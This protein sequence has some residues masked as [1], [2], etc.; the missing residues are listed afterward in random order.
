MLSFPSLN[1]PRSTATIT[2]VPIPPRGLVSRFA[3]LRSGGFPSYAG[4]M[5]NVIVSPGS[6]VTDFY[7]FA[8]DCS[9]AASIFSPT[10]ISELTRIESAAL[11]SAPLERVQ[12]GCICFA[13]HFTYTNSMPST[14]PPLPGTS[15]DFLLLASLLNQVFERV[16]KL[17]VRV[18]IILATGAILP[19]A[20]GAMGYP[21]RNLQIFTRIVLKHPSHLCRFVAICAGTDGPLELV[22]GCLLPALSTSV[23]W[24]HGIPVIPLYGVRCIAPGLVI[25]QEH[26]FGTHSV[27]G[28]GTPRPLRMML[29]HLRAGAA[30]YRQMRNQLQEV[31]HESVDHE[32]VSDII[33]QLTS[34]LRVLTNAKD[35]VGMQSGAAVSTLGSLLPPYDL[36]LM[37]ACDAILDGY[38]SVFRTW[39]TAFELMN[40]RRR[41]FV[42]SIRDFSGLVVCEQLDSLRYAVRHHSLNPALLRK[43]LLTLFASYPGP[44]ACVLDDVYED[45]SLATF[46]IV[47]AEAQSDGLA[48]IAS[49]YNAYTLA[50]FLPIPVRSLYL[51]RRL[52]GVAMCPWLVGVH[53]LPAVVKFISVGDFFRRPRT[54]FN[55]HGENINSFM[56][57]PCSA[58]DTY[59]MHAFATAAVT[60][61]PELYHPD[62]LAA[63]VAAVI[64]CIACEEQRNLVPGGFWWEEMDRS[65]TL[66][67]GSYPVATHASLGRYMSDVCSDDLFHTC[68]SAQCPL[69]ESH[70]QCPALSKF[71]LGVAL[72]GAALDF[73]QFRARYLALVLEYLGR[74][75][76]PQSPFKV[77]QKQGVLESLAAPLLA[78]YAELYMAS[79]YAHYR[80]Y[81]DTVNVFLTSLRRVVAGLSV[82]DVFEPMEVLL[83]GTYMSGIQ[84]WC[85]CMARLYVYTRADPS[86]V[87]VDDVIA[88]MTLPTHELATLVTIVTATGSSAQRHLVARRTA[89]GNHTFFHPVM[90]AAFG[91]WKVDFETHCVA[92]FE[93]IYA[94]DSA[95]LHELVA[96][97][98]PL[99]HEPVLL[100]TAGVNTGD[101]AE[102]VESVEQ[103]WEFVHF[104]TGMLNAFGEL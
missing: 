50:K 24:T 12:V 56:P 47:V 86:A 9:S 97:R 71:L 57:L 27:D 69:A 37:L 22:S 31:R 38:V 78:E 29:S 18:H 92:E 26:L 3:S 45:L 15:A 51:N 95:R 59:V 77:A 101:V 66:Y 44:N 17:S 7:L 4:E 70:R 6:D 74:N 1:P 64:C 73:D 68:L 87:S 99:A 94:R 96:P 43:S 75:H 60:G 93:R 90:Q 63:L 76:L 42:Q 33:I 5:P 100:L 91:M 103:K 65:I 85:R 32:S 84:G 53:S 104:A 14:V 16:K 82:G 48:A 80:D 40:A 21:D 13:E 30:S 11:S 23:D 79:K 46:R 88:R 61:D 55:G 102:S 2:S 25:L 36:A 54:A 49:V 89:M 19:G 10:Y 28:D 62:A 8:I 34:A 20:F 35:L 39:R 41:S 72:G 83:P 98:V 81:C 52:D 58:M 67:R